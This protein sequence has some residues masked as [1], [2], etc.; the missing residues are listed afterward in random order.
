VKPQTN[1]K[2]NMKNK[3]NQIRSLGRW[4]LLLLFAALTPQPSTV[5]A[6]TNAFTYQGQLTDGGSAANGSY[7]LSFTVFGGGSGGSALAGPVTNSAVQV[8]GGL[9]T[10]TLN[11]GSAVF[12]NGADRWL[13]IASRTNGSGAF[14][15]LTPRQQITS[16]P[17][18]ITAA[19]V[20]G[21]IPASQLSGTIS[22]AGTV[23]NGATTATSANTASA[24]VARDVSGNFTGG[25]ITAATGFSGSGANV[26]SLNADNVS[27]GTLADAR[28]STNVALLNSAQTFGANKT[29]GGGAQLLLDAG[30]TNAPSLSF[31]G[32]P[33]TGVFSPA[34]DTV[35]VATGGAERLRIGASGRLGIGTTV[36]SKELEVQK[37]GDVQ[38]GVQST[39]T[40]GHLWTIQSSAVSGGVNDASFQIIDRTP[41]IA[42]LLIQTN[43]N[44]GLG[45]APTN[46]LHVAGGISANGTVVANALSAGSAT[47]AGNTLTDGLTIGSGTAV[48]KILSTTNSLD[49]P[50][51]AAQSS[52]DLP[53]TL[54][55]AALGDAVFL[56]V[57]TS[58][59][60]SGTAYTAWVSATNTVTVRF[61]NST[62]AP[63]NPAAG[64]FRVAIMQF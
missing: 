27:S 15:L 29:F 13:E 9:F 17:Y 25:T 37:A 45:T 6:Q 16:A 61:L 31:N 20:T 32:D 1:Q 62:S 57:P 18:A 28:H 59:I 35:A 2:Q 8:S 36:P 52:S 33:N 4:S 22:T 46:K 39:D 5:F 24:I 48:T 60:F 49:F 7:D 56:G 53:I 38:I 63:L 64:I 12:T 42:R 44:V 11:L 40:G 34:A 58:A 10:V 55:N 19:N 54:T 21:L 23:A 50:N 26:T 51:T 43:G 47:I 41:N 3:C 30:V 14:G